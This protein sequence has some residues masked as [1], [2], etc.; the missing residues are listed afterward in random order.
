MYLQCTMT[1]V[2]QQKSGCHDQYICMLHQR[3]PTLAWPGTDGLVA[4]QE[5]AM[6]SLC[7]QTSAPERD[8]AL[9]QMQA[10]SNS[11]E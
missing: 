4:Q 8:V 1:E 6:E 5:G 9:L 11:G 2:V 3:D 10:G 7:T